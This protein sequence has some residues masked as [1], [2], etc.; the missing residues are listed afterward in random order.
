MAHSSNVV[1]TVGAA[2]GPTREHALQRVLECLPEVSI[3]VRVDEWVQRGVE[4]PDPEE[5]GHDHIWTGT[6]LSAQ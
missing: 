4:V 2:F 6:R 3:E 1:R 5:N